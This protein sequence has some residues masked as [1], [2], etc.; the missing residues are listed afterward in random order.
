MGN[1]LYLGKCID[2]T[3]DVIENYVEVVDETSKEEKPEYRHHK[4]HEAVT[5]VTE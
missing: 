4:S 1:T 2:V 5:E 3:D